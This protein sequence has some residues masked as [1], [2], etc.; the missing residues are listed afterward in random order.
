MLSIILTL[1]AV[2]PADSV[3]DAGER[4]APCASSDFGIKTC[5]K[6][7]VLKRTNPEGDL[8]RMALLASTAKT[9]ETSARAP[10]TTR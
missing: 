3:D 6:T 2:S 10:K 5:N 9:A 7:W 8:C 4:S 1:S